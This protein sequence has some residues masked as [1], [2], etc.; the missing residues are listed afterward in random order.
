MT[1]ATIKIYPKRSISILL[2]DY[3]GRYEACDSEGHPSNEGPC[4]NWFFADEIT[5]NYRSK[6]I[7]SK[8]AEYRNNGFPFF[9]IEHYVTNIAQEWVMSKCFRQASYGLS[10]IYNS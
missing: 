5:D 2:C 10:Q 3:Y 1:A 8:L 9:F 4:C 6:S 7:F